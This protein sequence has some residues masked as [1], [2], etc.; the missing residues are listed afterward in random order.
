MTRIKKVIS[1]SIL[2]SIIFI[3]LFGRQI[4]SYSIGFLFKTYASS[5]IGSKVKY[6]SVNFFWNKLSFKDVKV[7][8]KK[9]YELSMENIDFNI[10]FNRKQFFDVVINKPH[11]V[12]YKKDNAGAAKKKGHIHV[13]DYQIQVYD[14][15]IDIV[16]EDKLLTSV[17]FS[18]QHQVIENTGKISFFFDADRNTSLIVN[19]NNQQNDWIITSDFKQVKCNDFIY[20]IEPLYQKNI[21]K[22]QGTIDGR[23]IF[24][25][26]SNRMF[27]KFNIN[28]LN[29]CSSYCLSAKNLNFEIDS[30]MNIEN[31][32]FSSICLRDD[33]RTRLVINN[34]NINSSDNKWSLSDINGSIS[35][36]PG[37]GP[38]INCSCNAKKGNNKYPI[39]ID[40]KGYLHS[41]N[42]NWMDFSVFI[43]NVISSNIEVKISDLSKEAFK[44]N[45]SANRLNHD[46]LTIFHDLF[47]NYYRSCKNINI[48]NGFIDMNCS[49]NFKKDRLNTIEIE[50]LR[51]DD[52]CFSVKDD[53]ISHVQSFDISSSIDV[54]KKDF[55][56]I[57]SNVVIE[58]AS[59]EQS[60]NSFFF[61]KISN[62]TSQIKINDGHF[63]DSKISFLAD[64]SSSEIN[65][66]G[67]LSEFGL[68]I[69]IKG[70]PPFL[71][72][73]DKDID[74]SEG[75]FFSR[76][77]FKHADDND[78]I[79]GSFSLQ[80]DKRQDCLFSIQLNNLF[81]NLHTTYLECIDKAWIRSEDVFLNNEINGVKI[82]G[83]SS[84][85]LKYSDKKILLFLNGNDLNINNN[86]I[87]LCIDK[88][89]ENN[90]FSKNTNA[91][92]YK[93]D[94]K[95]KKW[96][97]NINEFNGH[98]DLP[99]YK[100]GFDA[101]RANLKVSNDNLLL[102]LKEVYS[103]EMFFLGNIKVDNNKFLDIDAKSFEGDI[104]SFMKFMSHFDPKFSI[105]SNLK[106]NTKGS[107]RF[108]F[109]LDKNEK[110][111]DWNFYCKFNDI[112]CPITE[113]SIITDLNFCLDWKKNDK[114]LEFSNLKAKIVNS[115]TQN[116]YF[117]SCPILKKD[118]EK[119]FI[120]N[121]DVRIDNELF[122]IFRTKGKTYL[123]DEKIQVLLED[124][125]SSF[126][127]ND[128]NISSFLFD[129]S[130]NLKSL[131]LSYNLEKNVDLFFQ[132]FCDIGLLPYISIPES[133][134]DFSSNITYNW[135]D[136]DFYILLDSIK[137]NNE[138]YKSF[139][140][141]AKKNN[142]LWNVY[143]MSFLNFIG[144]FN[145]EVN[146]DTFDIYDF[147]IQREE[148]FIIK[149]KGSYN[150]EDN[151]FSA[152]GTYCKIDLEQL[153]KSILSKI[154]P[155]EIDLKGQIESEM[156]L[157]FDFNKLKED[158]FYSLNANVKPSSFL[159][160]GIRIENKRMVNLDFSFEK[161][162][163]TGVDLEFYHKKLDL[164][165]VVFQ[166]ENSVYYFDLKKWKIHNTHI[167]FSSSEMDKIK[168]DYFSD[169]SFLLRK[170]LHL[171]KNV[172]VLCDIEY[173][174]EEKNLYIE[175]KEGVFSFFDSECILQDIFVRIASN[176]I[177]FNF[178]ILNGC[179]KFFI[180]NIIDLSNGLTGSLFLFENDKVTMDQLSINWKWEGNDEIS[181]N[182][183]KGSFY[184]I[185]AYFFEDKLRKNG[186][187]G[188]MKIDFSKTINLF[189]KSF[190]RSLD[191]L[192]L[193]NGY[194][195]KGKLNITN[196]SFNLD[197]TVIGKKFEIGGYEIKTLF[198]NIT[199]DDNKLAIQNMKI[200]D[201]SGIISMNNADFIFEE[202][203]IYFSI[204]RFELK[205]FRP[206]QL[207]LIDKPKNDIS[208]LVIREFVAS[209]IK[210][211]FND[212]Y[213]I[214]GY[215]HLNFINSFKRGYNIFDV[216]ADL[217][218]RILGLDLELLV[219]VKGNIEYQI[220]DSK[221][222]L[223]KIYDSYS[224]GHRSK[225]FLLNEKSP[226]YIDFDGNLNILIKMK[227]YVLFKFTENYIMSI[228]GNISKPQFQLQKKKWF[229]LE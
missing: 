127:N 95:T 66:L 80:K 79:S 14:G 65:L 23:A 137:F 62:L 100:L 177:L 200:S 81:N 213:S 63:S 169:M 115:K 87:S 99:F 154:Y 217:F 122:N 199:Y 117:I 67:T 104:S 209:D 145:F 82:R 166:A 9:N 141:K 58:N 124:K 158:S 91:L 129:N 72:A 220:K 123:E 77:S 181:I 29:I 134:K 222:Y 194:E 108:K 228:T 201:E 32:S 102:T 60:K 138:D 133:F 35:F 30:L 204:P 111:S 178:S 5:I 179:E 153:P 49:L 86:H 97:L 135:K 152:V 109:P 41:V 175:S 89:G 120:W 33:I 10:N 159:I 1:I 57:T 22:I 172:D 143:N 168:N 116:E 24:K 2:F 150:K 27:L 107:F 12:F 50:R 47:S 161:V 218:G 55:N 215:G 73:I 31:N 216:P 223:T 198:S 98:F 70:S 192:K 8:S 180:K 69:N 112:E 45:I 119:D 38:K 130:L 113:K 106:G 146:K 6:S 17:D 78:I 157:N 188:N 227:Q 53:I 110:D 173:D 34:A 184:G 205:E 156:S 13:L 25:L 48:T 28:D 170:G 191:S 151:I 182:E 176:Q 56:K 132:F 187:I 185:D 3:L 96:N 214:S 148:D 51:G 85:N 71:K 211:N 59:V 128:I 174:D 219:P 4:A 75:S 39:T 147:D 212:L 40:G 18:L 221:F 16:E 118:N 131:S 167:V 36:N 37:V 83:F 93:A 229:S 165:D 189:P 19:L 68:N 54:Q 186:L 121:F 195:F 46:I 225:F 103:N 76:I 21:D 64:G 144:S 190:Q 202:D 164:S 139:I 224:E 101:K 52:F 88:L 226:P 105:N 203:N 207:K 61:K 7:L 26:L 126:F 149:L 74:L 114:W 171:N 136:D 140:L 193:G 163:V 196:H 94:L 155:H 160:N 43:D 162:V 92:I 197:G 210:G 183:I 44:A 15:K 90:L 206:S 125:I 20:L 84:F 142:D 11:L 42:S 208:P